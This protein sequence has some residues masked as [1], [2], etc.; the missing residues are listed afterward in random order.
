MNLIFTFFMYLHAYKNLILLLFF[1]INIFSFALFA[2]DK[3]NAVHCKW[4]IPEV[5]LLTAAFLFGAPGELVAMVTLR[6]K[7]YNPKFRLALPLLSMI[8]VGVVFLA[9]SLKVA[10][11]YDISTN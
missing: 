9:V 4:R 8:Y 5:Y 2:L 1:L 11:V 6:H 7:L 10:G 3:Y